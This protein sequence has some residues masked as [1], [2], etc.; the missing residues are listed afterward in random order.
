MEI[1]TIEEFGSATPKF[2]RVKFQN[3]IKREISKTSNSR[4]EREIWL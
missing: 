1:E 3:V 2:L 4:D